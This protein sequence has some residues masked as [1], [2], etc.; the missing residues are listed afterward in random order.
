MSGVYVSQYVSNVVYGFS[1]KKRS[2]KKKGPI[3]TAPWK[4]SGPQYVAVDLKGNLLEVDS[5]ALYP[6]NIGEGLNMCGPLA[7]TIQDRQ[8]YADAV[9]SLDALNG[10]VAI[11]NQWDFSN[12]GLAPG[13]ISVCSVAAGCTANLTNAA[14]SRVAGVAVAPN[15]DCW[16]SALNSPD[17]GAVLIYFKGCAGAGEQATGYQNPGYGGLDIDAHGNLVAMSYVI[18]SY[19]T[20]LYVYSGCNPACTVVAG[21]FNL[22]GVSI[23]GHLNAKSTKF[24]AADS[25]YGQVDIYSYTPT[26][27]K[28]LY[29]FNK[30]L[31]QGDVVGSVAVNP[32]SSE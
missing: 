28:Y 12:Y 3:C 4:M 6:I 13:S 16:A 32:A 31:S 24:M 8:G 7:A 20:Q 15:G 5:G 14:M 23:S 9:A 11:A 1:H 17:S 29:S 2:Q 22:K 18:S 30:G 26:R 27:V 25:Q 21:P 10:V 19:V